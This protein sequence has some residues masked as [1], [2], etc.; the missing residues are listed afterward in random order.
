MAHS[1]VHRR[2]QIRLKEYDYSQPGVYYV[3]M[4]TK[5]RVHF[6]GEVVDGRMNENDLAAIA[7]S[8]WNELP[9]QYP[10]VQLDQFVIMPNHVHGIIILMDDMVGATSRRPDMGADSRLRNIGRS[11]VGSRH[12]STLQRETNTLGDIVGSFKSA[13]TRRINE[14]SGTPGA[15]VWQ[16][17]YYDHIIRDD[18]SLNRIRNYIATNPQQ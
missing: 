11:T 18:K 7:Q 12:D 8:C 16:R 5:D 2:K 14:L 17:G 9:E 15:R 1:L 6:F 4:C 3:T 13:V 10:I